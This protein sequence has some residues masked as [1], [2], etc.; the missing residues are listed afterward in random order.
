MNMNNEYSNLAVFSKLVSG[1]QYETHTINGLEISSLAHMSDVAAK[2]N[3]QTDF[4]TD[5]LD[6][7]DI[8]I[9][10]AVEDAILYNLYCEADDSGGHGLASFKHS[11]NAMLERI[12][13]DLSFPFDYLPLLH[14]YMR[15]NAVEFTSYS[16][17]E[18]TVYDLRDDY[19][20]GTYREHKGASD[21]SIVFTCRDGHG[22]ESHQ[23]TLDTV[24]DWLATEICEHLHFVF[25]RTARRLI[26]TVDRR[27]W[28][29]FFDLDAAEIDVGAELD[30]R[31]NAA[32]NV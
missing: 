26:D 14:Y 18:R 24:E 19:A 23:E 3:A 25:Q 20:A 15:R 27:F 11:D 21:V 12:Q 32:L 5:E 29:F 4:N 28:V 1:Y 31:L 9:T 10:S 2:I 13:E 22:G 17:I 30:R 8:A 7:A 16:Y 6:G